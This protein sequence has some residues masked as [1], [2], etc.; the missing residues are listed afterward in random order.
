MDN[1]PLYMRMTG[2]SVSN[3]DV[4]S[5][6]AAAASL[7]AKWGKVKEVRPIVAKAAAIAA[8]LGGPPGAPQALI[9]EVE[10]AVQTH[11]SAFLAQDRPLEIGI[12]AGVAVMT[13]LAGAHG[14]SGWN[15]ADVYA[16]ALWLALSAQAPLSDE[17][18]EA[19]RSEVLEAARARSLSAADKARE[20]HPVPDPNELT[21]SVST[22]GVYSA[23]LKKTIAATVEALRRNAV[24]D[25]EELDFVWWI[26][27]N[28]SKILNR[29]LATIHEPIRLVAAGVEGAAY[30]RRL[31]ADAH[32]DLVLRTAEADPTLTLK[33]LVEAAGSD[34]E[35]LAAAV[36][37]GDIA[38]ATPSVFPLMCTL[39]Q[40]TAPAPLGDIG[41]AATI[42]GAR[43]LLEAVLLRQM[44]EGTSLV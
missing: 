11:A 23:N 26:Q 43:A 34:A 35:V 32:R 19:L 18:R 10:A 12:C 30:L 8:A 4:D 28:R 41:Q 40:G 24:L 21:I 37:H 25:R 2:M 20:R 42:W 38:A 1:I 15:I 3:D 44:S 9:D 29:P 31:P 13:V 7:A 22:D 39:R 14:T 6:R 17:K 36:G 5:R 16:A 33:E 27:L